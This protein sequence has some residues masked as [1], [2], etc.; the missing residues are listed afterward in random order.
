MRVARVAHGY[1]PRG[2]VSRK[3]YRYLVL[4]SRVRDPFLRDRAWRV[5]ERLNHEAMRLEA[6]ALVGP[7]DFRAFRTSADQRLDTVRTIFRAELSTHHTDPRIVA[8]EIEG[9]R[10][11]HH[12][13]RII[14]GTITDVGRDRLEPGAVSRGLETGE[15]RSLGITAPPDGL[16]L[17]TLPL[18]DE[19][20]DKWPDH[21][22]NR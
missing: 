16:Y 19:G 12:M 2:H 5:A 9:D 18:D 20:E 14:V 17:A 10:F 6:E 15:R 4:C 3:T 21:L 8:L 11:L 1:D 13:V 7:H 22:S